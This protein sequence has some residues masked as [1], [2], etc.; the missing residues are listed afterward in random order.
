VNAVIGGWQIAGI[1][2][3]RTGTPFSL[4][5]TTTQTGWRAIRPNATS[6]GALSRSD[7]SIYRWFDPSAYSLPAPFTYGNSARNSLFGPGDMVFDASALKNFRILERV[8]A[9]VRGEFFNLP[10]H[11]NF[12]NPA[13]NISVPSTVGRI[14]S[15]GDPRQVQFG[16]KFLF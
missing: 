5:I 10:N 1:T 3:L 16:I 14:T 9:Q 2:Y 6:S 12:G 4:S 8:T 13:T 15:A 11:T 7:R